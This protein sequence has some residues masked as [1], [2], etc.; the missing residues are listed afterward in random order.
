[1]KIFNIV[2]NYLVQSFK[3]PKDPTFTT[4]EETALKNIIVVAKERVWL[5]DP[6]NCRE[7]ESE[8]FDEDLSLD[9]VEKIKKSISIAENYLLKY[10]KKVTD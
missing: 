2:W 4:S 7:Y 8:N 9:G 6:L 10:Q 1:M 5:N 3:L